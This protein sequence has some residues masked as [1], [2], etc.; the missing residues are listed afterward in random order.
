M[1]S[2]DGSYSQEGISSNDH[3][4]H[5]DSQLTTPPSSLASPDTRSDSVDSIHRE[6]WCRG[7]VRASLFSLWL[8]SLCRK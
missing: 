2:A 8:L 4:S 3:A 5:N 7:C 6:C 1:D